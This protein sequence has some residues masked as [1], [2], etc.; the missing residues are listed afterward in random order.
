MMFENLLAALAQHRQ[1]DAE[2]AVRSLRAGDRLE[3]KVDRRAAFQSGELRA[4]MRKAAGLRGHLV[5]IDQAIE[6]VQD[7]ADGLN[8]IGRR[9]YPDY[10]VSASI[11]EPFEGR[12]QNAADIVGRMIRLNADAQH[13][14]LAHR[15]PA[16]RHIPD[17][18]RGQHQI[19]V[20]HDLGDGRC[21]FRGDGPLHSLQLRFAGGI[22]Q[23]D[24]RGTH[25]PSCS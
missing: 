4:D 19:F 11:E 20:A 3:E 13:S 14:A 12:K 7:G 25:R 1:R 8:G 22:V 10:C 24:A 23:D 16:P 6:R 18:G 17:L 5:G 2:A 21:Y 9:V 15:V